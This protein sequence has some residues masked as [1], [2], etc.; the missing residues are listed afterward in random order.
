M[1]SGVCIHVWKMLQEQREQFDIHKYGT[2]VIEPLRRNQKIP[3]R[4]V[5]AGKPIF[6]IGRLF[7]ATLQLVSPFV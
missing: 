7:L 1:C 4:Q 2:K 5:V 6:Q 3:F